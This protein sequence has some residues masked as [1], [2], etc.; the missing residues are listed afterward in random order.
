MPCTLD[1]ST[2]AKLFSL[3][4]LAFVTLSSVLSARFVDFT[5]TS[6]LCF[7]LEWCWT[8]SSGLPAWT[9]GSGRDTAGS[10]SRSGFGY[11]CEWM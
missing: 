2:L 1:K 7:H 10:Q 4:I 3:L 9:P 6:I 5:F 8:S 11:E